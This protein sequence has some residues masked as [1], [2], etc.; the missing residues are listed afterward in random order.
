MLDRPLPELSLL[1]PDVV[2]HR[3]ND[4]KSADRIIPPEAKFFNV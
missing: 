3:R 4:G 1:W 2:E